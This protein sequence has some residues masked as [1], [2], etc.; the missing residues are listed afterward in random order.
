MLMATVVDWR[1]FCLGQVGFA[2]V[3]LSYA[4]FGRGFGRPVTPICQFL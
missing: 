2:R 1:I 3:L 4:R